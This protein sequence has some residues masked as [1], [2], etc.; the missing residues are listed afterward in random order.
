LQT[1]FLLGPAELERWPASEIQQLSARSLR[2]LEL[3]PA[4]AVLSCARGYVGNDSGI[5]HLAAALGVS[6]TAIFGPTK[7]EHWAPLGQQVR[8][9][10]G[11]GM[12]SDP[13]AGVS[14]DD[15][16]ESVM[17]MND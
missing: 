17:T 15:V 12:P 10:Q 11:T 16:V 6:T 1:V 4:L 8:A 3:E 13:F 5:T 2:D 7:A 14:V 9:L